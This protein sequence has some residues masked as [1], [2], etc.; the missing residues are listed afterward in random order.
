MG[1]LPLKHDQLRGQPLS[2]NHLSLFQKY[3]LPAVSPLKVR[4]HTP[5]SPLLRIWSVHAVMLTVSAQD[6]TSLYPCILAL[7]LALLVTFMTYAL[8]CRYLWCLSPTVPDLT[9]KLL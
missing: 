4:L 8:S 1:S 3:E 9:H 5:P 6:T 2:E 7:A